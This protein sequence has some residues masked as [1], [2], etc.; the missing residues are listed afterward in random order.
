MLGVPDDDPEEPPLLPPPLPPP[1]PLD[2][3]EL[4]EPEPTPQPAPEANKTV[5]KQ[6]LTHLDFQRDTAIP[7]PTCHCH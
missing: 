1:P 6:T 3:P 5:P 2:W 4:D 7:P